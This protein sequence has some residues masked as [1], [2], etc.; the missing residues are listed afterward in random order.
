MKLLLDENGNV[1]LREEKPVYVD[2]EEKEIVVDV[3]SLFSKVN[4]LNSEAASKKRT[5]RD[6]QEEMASFTKMFEGV[7]DTE[8]WHQTAI[9]ALETVQNLSDKKMMDAK[10]VEKFKDDIKSAYEDKILALQKVHI[11]DTESKDKIIN[12]KENQIYSLM[13]SSQ[14]AS[15]PFFSGEKPKTILPPEIAESY[16][17]HHF[18]VEETDDK[19]LVVIGYL[20][21]NK[22]FS[23]SSPGEP[24][25]FSEAM[26]EI[27]NK[28]PMK[29][30]L[31]SSGE[32]GSGSQSNSGGNDEADKTSVKALKK[33][34]QEALDNGNFQVAVGLKNQI[35]EL[36]MAA[37]R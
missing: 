32:G 24:A 23:R 5:I 13:V 16:F 22:I 20:D 1:V 15:S 27:I 17:A 35:H 28:Y 30:R 7:E 11:T 29:D 25:S 2:D 12:D 37:R 33:K 6:L 26:E 3:P 19:K 4:S 36:E 18:K 21:G 31:L 9:E 34:R 8:K 14:F 10:Q